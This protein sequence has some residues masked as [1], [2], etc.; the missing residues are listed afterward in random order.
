MISEQLAE[1][2]RCVDDVST[3]S[4]LTISL[5]HKGVHAVFCEP[6]QVL[7]RDVETPRSEHTKSYRVAHCTIKKSNIERAGDPSD[8]A[9]MPRP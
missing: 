4:I 6:G 9:K 7:E 2:Q 5:E 3:C 1:L 8:P